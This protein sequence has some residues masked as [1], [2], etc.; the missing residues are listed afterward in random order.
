MWIIE[1]ERLG[2]RQLRADDLEWVARLMGDPLVMRYYPAL[3]N[4]NDCEQWIERNRGRYLENGFGSWALIEK[5]TQLPIGECGLARVEL[6]GQSVVDISYKIFPE[7]WGAGFAS[8]AV[9]ACL[10][11]AADWGIHEILAFISEANT[12]SRRVLEKNGFEALRTVEVFGQ[13]QQLW[14]KP[15]ETAQS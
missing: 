1:T 2:F 15:V 5:S 11:R 12:G 6:E 14:Q 10:A 8:E 9:G 3:R 7:H 13:I 4:R